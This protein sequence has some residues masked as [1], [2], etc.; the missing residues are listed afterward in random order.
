M[1]SNDFYNLLNPL[2]TCYIIDS[3]SEHSWQN[4]YTVN[5]FGYVN[6]P[7][8]ISPLNKCMLLSLYMEYSFL[9]KQMVSLRE[10]LFPNSEQSLSSELYLLQDVYNFVSWDSFAYF[11]KDLS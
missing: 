6:A 8:F 4:T 9:S 2:T 10:M 5:R 1:Y 3:D 11:Q 7:A